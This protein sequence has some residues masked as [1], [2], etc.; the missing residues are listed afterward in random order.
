[1]GRPAVLL[2]YVERLIPLVFVILLARTGKGTFLS[3]WFALFLSL[4]W[5]LGL[6]AAY[7]IWQDIRL[8]GPFSSPNSLASVLLVLIR[9]VLFGAIRYR[10]SLP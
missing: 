8:F 4:L 1:D 5:Y 9:G 3:V 6:V 7:P 10:A 2:K